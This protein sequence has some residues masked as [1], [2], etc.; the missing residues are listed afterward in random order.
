MD[1]TY[2][3]GGAHDPGPIGT[4][5][6]IDYWDNL[7]CARKVSLNG[8]AG[9]EEVRQVDVA[10]LRRPIEHGGPGGK[11][12]TKA[13]GLDEEGGSSS[14]GLARRTSNTGAFSDLQVPIQKRVVNQVARDAGLSLDGASVEINRDADLIGRGLYGHT[15]PDGTITPYPNALSSKEDLVRTIGHERM[16]VMQI[17]L[18]GQAS[19]LEQEAAWERAAYASE[20]HFWNFFNGRLG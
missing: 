8:C 7:P 11:A 6:E 4:Y 17:Q 5:S 2:C 3:W 14:P 9:P 12:R 1:R 16:H 13:Y 18:Y 20:N 10:R 19:S 15:S